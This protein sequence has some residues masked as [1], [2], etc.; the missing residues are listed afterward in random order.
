MANCHF[1]RG[2][3][4]K[5]INI[6]EPISNSRGQTTKWEIH[7]TKLYFYILS[8]QILS[9]PSLYSEPHIP[10]A[11][12]WNHQAATNKQEVFRL[13]ARS[14]RATSNLCS[15]QQQWFSLQSQE[16]I[17]LWG[18]Q[19]IRKSHWSHWNFLVKRK[20]NT[21]KNTTDAAVCRGIQRRCELSNISHRVFHHKNLHQNFLNLNVSSDKLC[22]LLPF[23][24]ACPNDFHLEMQKSA[25]FLM[26]N[27]SSRTLCVCNHGPYEC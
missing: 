14:N 22:T 5:L 19:L 15:T 3:P 7:I 10:Q 6:S 24:I 12:K 26:F 1:P 13:H 23:L 17:K 9:H 2:Q 27:Q 25:V 16:R 4:L 20:K 18:V 21:T 11:V 8:P